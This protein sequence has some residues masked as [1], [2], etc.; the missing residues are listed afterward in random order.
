MRCN[1]YLSTAEPNGDGTS[2]VFLR[3]LYRSHTEKKQVPPLRCA[4]VGMTR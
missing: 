4:A 2:V 3:F 1:A